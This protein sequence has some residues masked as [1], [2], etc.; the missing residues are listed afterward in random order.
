MNNSELQSKYR[1]APSARYRFFLYCPNDG[2]SFWETEADRDAAAADLIGEY[3]QDG[4][5]DEDVTGIT[6][7]IA[8]HIATETDRKDRVG[9]LDD[10]GYDEAGKYWANTDCDYV[11][12][13]KLKPFF[14]QP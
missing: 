6:A 10:D 5:W 9:K 14:T 8:T 4:E 13:Y 3:L 7:G 11:C 12:N 1:T 2:I